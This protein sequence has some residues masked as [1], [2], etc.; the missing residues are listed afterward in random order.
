MRLYFE[1]ILPLLTVALSSG[2]LT[3]R[4][5]IKKRD[6]GLIS[7]GSQASSWPWSEDPL[8]SLRTLWNFLK[9]THPR[10]ETTGSHAKS[11]QEKRW[12]C[13]LSLLISI[14]QNPRG[15]VDP[16]KCHLMKMVTSEARIR[17]LQQEIVTRSACLASYLDFCFLPLKL[18][19]ENTQP[20]SNLIKLY[21]RSQKRGRWSRS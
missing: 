12:K 10:E 15:C 21:I 13:L 14:V 18:K 8:K 5:T 2:I 16:E 6:K 9:I 19:P 20:N 4:P 17:N 1:H 3:S 11:F 7:N